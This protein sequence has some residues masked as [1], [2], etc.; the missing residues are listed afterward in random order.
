MNKVAIAS[1][2]PHK[3]TPGQFATLFWG[4]APRTDQIS[5]L[6][7]PRSEAWGFYPWNVTPGR[8]TSVELREDF[9]ALSQR[10][11]GFIG[12]IVFFA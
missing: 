4:W 7:L 2:R 6:D 12:L 3:P 1:G 9:A 11:Y 8:S 10:M 5:D